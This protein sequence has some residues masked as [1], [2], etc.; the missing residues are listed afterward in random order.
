MWI[1]GAQCGGVPT[2][3]GHTN[4]ASI[5][6]QLGLDWKDKKGPRNHKGKNSLG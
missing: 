5:G 4:D 6:V 1:N 2:F 3:M